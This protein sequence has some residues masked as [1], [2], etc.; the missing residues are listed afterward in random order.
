MIFL[1]KG[2]SQTTLVKTGSCKNSSLCLCTGLQFQNRNGRQSLSP[3][4]FWTPGRSPRKTSSAVQQRRLNDQDQLSGTAPTFVTKR[5]ASKARCL[6]L[7]RF[8]R[9]LLC[10]YGKTTKK[11]LAQKLGCMLSVSACYSWVFTVVESSLCSWAI[12]VCHWLI[13]DNCSILSPVF[14]VVFCC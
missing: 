6:F 14:A 3:L 4:Y 2:R 10:A 5:L 13:K 11:C 8:S 12:R 9:V 1:P 7:W